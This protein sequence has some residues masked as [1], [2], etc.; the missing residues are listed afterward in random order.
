M[1]NFNNLDTE[2]LEV[3]YRNVLSVL[4]SV[5]FSWVFLIQ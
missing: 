1:F 4:F 2:S 3:V 5:V